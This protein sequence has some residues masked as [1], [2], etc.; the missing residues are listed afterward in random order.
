MPY[1]EYVILLHPKIVLIIKGENYEIRL[2][3]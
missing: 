1:A 3:V 2:H